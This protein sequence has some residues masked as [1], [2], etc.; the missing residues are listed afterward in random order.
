MTRYEMTEHYWNSIFEEVDVIESI[1]PIK[2]VEIENGIQWLVH[3]SN[4]I[5]DFGCGSGNA[6][7]RAVSLG[8]EM[9]IGIDLSCKAIELAKKNATHYDVQEKVEFKCGGVD[10][11][12]EI[13]PASYDG[14]ILFNIIDNMYPT[15]AMEV[16]KYLHKML[17]SRGRVLMK[18]NP[19]Y[20]ESHFSQNHFYRKIMD[21]FYLESSGVY[22]WNLSYEEVEEFLNPYFIIEDYQVINIED[23]GVNNRLFFLRAM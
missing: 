4:S 7:L 5:L 6:L 23:H 12:R 13:T 16:I 11:L 9:G 2:Y 14:A 17:K 19:H 8:L 21:H 15:D 22:F 18:L 10:L 20:P 1:E 3:D